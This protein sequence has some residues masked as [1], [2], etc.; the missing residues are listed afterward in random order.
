MIL[1]T[2]INYIKYNYVCS[3]HKKCYKIFTDYSNNR[4]KEPEIILYSC[5][6]SVILYLYTQTVFK[7][8]INNDGNMY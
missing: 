7:M 8:K 1:E 3:S 4:V 5:R 6:S 2:H